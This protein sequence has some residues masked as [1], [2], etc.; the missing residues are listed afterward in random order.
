MKIRS[1]EL[2]PEY[3]KICNA[4][5]GE[6]Q[7]EI[8]QEAKILSDLG[9]D[10]FEWRADYYRDSGSPETVEDTLRLLR[11]AIKDRPLIVSARSREPGSA[12]SQRQLDLCR[13]AIRSGCVDL[14][15]LELSLGED[16]PPLL[17][18]AQSQGVSTIVSS[19]NTRETPSQES[20]VETLCRCESFQPA[21]SKIAVATNAKG[22][23]LRLL[24]AMEEVEQRQGKRPRIV[25]GMGS[26]GNISRILPSFFGSVLTYASGLTASLEGQINVSDLRTILSFVR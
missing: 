4:L 6:S 21:L 10:L 25:V 12:P 1:L 23:V 26:K 9:T 15:E 16:L 13:Q 14:I 17:Q 8:I 2:N 5:L 24:L 7:E 22:D 11:K 20:M 18:Y 3:P 19:Y